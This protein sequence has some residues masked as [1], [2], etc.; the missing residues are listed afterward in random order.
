MRTWNVVY[1]LVKVSNLLYQGNIMLRV[2]DI[3]AG[4][5]GLS[6]G[7][8]SV[9]DRYGNPVFE[10]VLSIEMDHHA[11]ETLK[12]RTFFRHFQKE[13]PDDYYRYL[14][15]E[16]KQ[17]E[18]FLKHPVTTEK[19]SQR[20]WLARLGPNGEST[21]CVR[22]RIDMAVG[23][24][25]DWVL[26]GGPPCQ[27]Y[28]LAG[29]SRNAGNAQYVPTKDERQHLYLEYLQILADHRPTAFILEN[30]K[31]LLSATLENE[32]IFQRILEDL[33]NPAKALEREGRHVRQP[34]SSGYRIHSLVERRMFENGNILGSVIQAE[35]YG[36]P[37]ARHR[38]ILLGVRDDLDGANPGILTV[39][40]EIASEDVLKSLPKVRSGL[41]CLKDSAKTWADCL[42]SQVKSRWANEGTIEADSKEL[43]YRIRRLLREIKPPEND[44]GGEFIPSEVTSDYEENWYCDPK[45]GGICNHST[46]GHI[47]EDLYRYIYAACYAQIYEKSPT[48]RNFPTDLLPDHE[49]VAS[50]LKDGSNFSDRFRVQISSRPSTTIMSHISKDGHYYIH[51]DPSQC[52]SLTV[53]EAARL[54]T[55]PDNYFFCGPRTAQYVQVGNAVPPLLARQIAEIV[56]DLLFQAGV[57]V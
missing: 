55:F 38:V 31:G 37:Q 42:K 26:I 44:R 6:E 7:F 34:C 51:P 53:R 8:S 33:R 4:P 46:R 12:L 17:D 47:E 19:V 9:V 35:K 45:I 2:V 16:I 11:H 48:L 23:D 29:R 40:N 50:A 57:K 36:I 21:E 43:S 54:Q 14:R 56:Y 13:I 5:G 15:Q 41:S 52:R 28:S 32:R 20:C 1:I 3:F 27:A 49:S 18:L 30:V 22:E 25:K 10:I 24:E 39:K